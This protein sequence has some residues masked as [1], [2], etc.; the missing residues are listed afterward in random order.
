MIKI[1]LNKDLKDS[2]N[3]SNIVFSFVPCPVDNGYVNL[4]SLE[5]PEEDDIPEDFTFIPGPR[6]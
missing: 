2:F 3:P 6:F 5:D 1:S 4:N